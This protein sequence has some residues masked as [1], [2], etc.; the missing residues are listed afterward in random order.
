[1]GKIGLVAPFALM[2]ASA[3]AQAPRDVMI[4]AYPSAD[5]CADWVLEREQPEGHGQRL[6]GWLLG[7]VSGY[8]AYGSSSG[9]V[10]NGGN[11]TALLAWV[12]NYCRANPLD[13]LP[14]AGMALVRELRSRKGE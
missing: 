11:G 9:N 7:F 10:A 12:D 3:S 4:Y 2:A 1:M 13:V 8:N 6:Q 14:Q 5:S